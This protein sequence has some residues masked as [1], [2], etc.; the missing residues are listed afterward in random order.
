M[1]AFGGLSCLTFDK[2][3]DVLAEPLTISQDT[4]D[5]LESNI[6]LFFTGK[7]REASDILIEQ[8]TRSKQGDQDMIDNLNRIKEIGIETRKYLEKGQPN[9][10]GELLHT[11]WV[12]KKKRSRKMSDPFLDECYELARKN[13]A[14]GGKLIGA[15]GGG[16]F[17]FYCENNHKL[18]VIEAMKKCGLRWEQFGFDFD[19]AKILVNT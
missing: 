9:M 14:S 5:Q 6:L 16:F 3:G 4:A 10:L 1:A 19:G 17:M 12:V 8:D 15:G 7:E 13:G 18:R 11:H 2:N